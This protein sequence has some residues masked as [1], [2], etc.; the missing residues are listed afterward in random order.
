MSKRRYRRAHMS[1]TASWSARTSPRPSAPSASPSCA[2]RTYQ[3][4]TPKRSSSG[5]RDGKGGLSPATVVY[6]HRIIKHALGQAVKWD[7]LAKNPADAVK[8]PRMERKPPATYDTTEA[9]DVLETL[10]PTRMYIP[11]VLGNA[12]R[13][14]AGRDNSPALAVDRPRPRAARRGRQHRTTCRAGQCPGQGHQGK[15]LPHHRPVGPGRRP[16][17]E[18]TS[19]GRQRSYY[20]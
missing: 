17:Y 4:F 18:P 8:P 1:D 11:T 3:T 16:N 9:V 10:R 6:M 15:A 14:A 13:N 19:C 7:M 20:G 2:R 12:L 5:R